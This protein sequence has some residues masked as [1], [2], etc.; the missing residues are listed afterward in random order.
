MNN[1][2]DVS[3]ANSPTADQICSGSPAR[4][5]QHPDPSNDVDEGGEAEH[6]KCEADPVGSPEENPVEDTNLETT[7]T[8]KVRQWSEVFGR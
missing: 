1:E 4:D 5:E 2:P 6:A 3:A 7:E 8:P